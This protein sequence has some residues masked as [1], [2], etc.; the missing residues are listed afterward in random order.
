MFRKVCN[1]CLKEQKAFMEKEKMLVSSIFMSFSHNVFRSPF[2]QDLLKNT[3]FFNHSQANEYFSAAFI[4]L[5]ARTF[6]LDQSRNLSSC[7]GLT[8]YLTILTLT[9]PRK[10]PFENICLGRNAGNQRF[11]FIF[12][13]HNVF[14]SYQ[15]QILPF[16]SY[17]VCRLQ[18]FSIW[19][20]LEISLVKN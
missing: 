13:S 16:Q 17:L 19:T 5:S 7:E 8:V 3:I 2:P 15:G 11:F 18:M 12:F 1:F 4:L 6:S 9:A 10:K 20:E 14:L